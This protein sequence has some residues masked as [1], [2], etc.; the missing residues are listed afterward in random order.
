MA[1]GGRSSLLIY[2]AFAFAAGSPSICQQVA[3]KI[4][5]TA[6]QHLNKI[7]E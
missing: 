6:E 1:Y 5:G 3:L 7:Q 2:S 4:G